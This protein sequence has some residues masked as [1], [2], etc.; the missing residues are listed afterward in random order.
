MRM[1]KRDQYSFSWQ[2]TFS[3]NSGRNL[4]WYFWEE[5]ILRRNLYIGQENELFLFVIVKYAHSEEIR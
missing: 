2:Q 1:I 4:N 5:F 3:T